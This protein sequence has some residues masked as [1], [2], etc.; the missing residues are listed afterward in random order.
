MQSS[1]AHG[2]SNRGLAFS[3]RPGSA[4]GH[5]QTQSCTHPPLL[6]DCLF[7]LKSRPFPSIPCFHSI[8]RV[9]G[10]KGEM[11]GFLQCL[12]ISFLECSGSPPHLDDT[13]SLLQGLILDAGLKVAWPACWSAQHNAGSRQVS[14]L[15]FMVCVPVRGCER[16][17]IGNM[18]TWPA[19]WLKPV[20]G[21]WGVCAQACRSCEEEDFS[22]IACRG[23]TA[24]AQAHLWTR[25]LGLALYPCNPHLTH[26]LTWRTAS[27]LYCCLLHTPARPI[28]SPEAYLSNPYSFF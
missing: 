11:T 16:A 24:K 28:L 14:V 15:R 17:D 13:G 3:D 7:K 9:R 8:P 18:L 22:H 21:S 23:R 4:P 26:S 20:W 19:G 27:D 1:P 6:L 25:T 10:W 2:E 5:L 12:S